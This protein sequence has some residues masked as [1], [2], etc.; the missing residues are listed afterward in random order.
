M[1]FHSSEKESR[2]VVFDERNDSSHISWELK[3]K[4][5]GTYYINISMDSSPPSRGDDH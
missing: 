5:I 2:G 4:Q 1:T 3:V